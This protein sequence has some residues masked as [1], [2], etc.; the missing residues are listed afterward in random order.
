MEASVPSGAGISGRF[1][2]AQ[3][4]GSVEHFSDFLFVRLAIV[5]TIH[6]FNWPKAFLEPAA[7]LAELLDVILKPAAGQRSGWQGES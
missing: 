1:E 6:D 3:S 7:F 4:L 2:D 5:V